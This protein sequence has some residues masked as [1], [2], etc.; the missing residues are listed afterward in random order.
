MTPKEKNFQ[1]LLLENTA[2]FKAYIRSICN[3]NCSD[4]VF[5]RSCIIMWNKFDSF[6]INTNFCA[7]GLKI[8]KYESSNYFRVMSRNPVKFDQLEF[9]N[10]AEKLIFE[11]NYKNEA[12]E[13][14]QFIVSKLD[15]KWQNLIEI[16]TQDCVKDEAIKNKK[17]KQT[18]Y[19][20]FNKLKKIIIKKFN[21]L[22]YS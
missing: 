14:L 16:Y 9:D 7:W 19:N 1:K 17:S 22:T 5:Q 18:Y 21:L 10:N 6:D 15:I 13:K 12:L 2:K 20:N 11:S 8:I 3:S 4:D